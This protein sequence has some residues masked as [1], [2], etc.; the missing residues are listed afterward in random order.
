[1]S[2]SSVVF[3]EVPEDEDTT[4]TASLIPS[5]AAIHYYVRF[6]GLKIGGEFV[7]IPS[8]VWKIDIAYGR[9]GVNVD[10]GSTYTG[11]HLQAYRFFRDTFREY[12]EDDDDGIKLVKGRQAMDTCYMVLNHVSKRLAFPSV[13]FI[14]DDFDQPLKS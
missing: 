5:V 7:Q 13:A 3:D 10:T 12:M 6:E 2:S 11:F 8:Y 9:S 1:M 14:F 4:I